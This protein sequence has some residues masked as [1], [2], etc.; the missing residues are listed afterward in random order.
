M[1]PKEMCRGATEDLFRQRLE[2][3]IDMRHELIKLSSVI[4]WSSLS[5]E[6]GDFYSEEMGRPAKPIRL[7]AGLILLQHTY[8]LS[9]EETVLRWREN[10]YWQY[11]CGFDYFHHGSPIDPTSLIKWRQRIGGKGCEKILSLTI[12]A[13]IES[14]VITKRDLKR[15]IVD[16]T[17]QEK[18]IAFPTDSGLYLAG[19][20]KLVKISKDLGIKL[21]QTYA[22]KAKTLSVQVSRYAHARQ[23]KR[24]R[25]SLRTLKCFLGRVFRDVKRKASPDLLENTAL[26]HLLPLIEKLLNQTKTSKNKIYS[27]HAPEVECIAKGKARK[28]Y[29]F[30]NK[31][32]LAIP[33]KKPF[34]VGVS[35]F[36][37]NPYDGHTLKDSLE[38]VQKLT[39]IRVDQAF[40]DQGYRNHDVLNV[41][42][43]HSRQKRGVT[44]TIQ[45]H[46]KRRQ[47]IEPIIGHL[48]QDGKLGRNYL[49]GLIGNEINAILS[50]AGFNLRTILNKIKL[51][52]Q[53]LFYQA[54]LLLYPKNRFYLSNQ[55]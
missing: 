47:A 48:K 4:D 15:V 46:L 36:Q 29:E 23:F 30:G 21:R 41:E 16:T 9:D 22:R 37:C 39:G 27:L 17:V 28:H 13:G 1:K 53:K 51:I 8:G 38:K 5:E 45:R 3:I 25:K 19:L 55:I 32:G 2:N 42:V 50:G 44:K 43:F 34:V 52:F 6:F 7:M 54:S 18:N 33:L 31:V 35:S 49:K 26:V 12:E 40:V 11:F 24:M 20:E 14:D 10:P